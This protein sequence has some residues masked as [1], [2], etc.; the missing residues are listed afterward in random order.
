MSPCSA[1]IADVLIVLC[2]S[3]VMGVTAGVSSGIKSA[4]AAHSVLPVVRPSRCR[5][6]LCADCSSLVVSSTSGT[7][8]LSHVR[9]RSAVGNLASLSPND[10]HVLFPV[11][12]ECPVDECHG[13][14]NFSASLRWTSPD[15]SMSY[16][17]RNGTGGP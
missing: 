5:C 8:G 11:F 6:S 4:I 16:E 14:G 3:S 17:G 2:C 13:F 9:V 12:V 10:S 1:V 15:V 7:G